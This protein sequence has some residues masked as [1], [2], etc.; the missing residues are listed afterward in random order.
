ML[1][2]FI[3]KTEVFGVVVLSDGGIGGSGEHCHS[4]TENLLGLGIGGERFLEVD[5]LSILRSLHGSLGILEKGELLRGESGLIILI[6]EG[7][8]EVGIVLH[9]E[10]LLKELDVLDGVR[11]IGVFGEHHIAGLDVSVG[12]AGTLESDGTVDDTAKSSVEVFL[13]EVPALVGIHVTSFGEELVEVGGLELGG[14]AGLVEVGA[15]LAL[16]E[17]S[18]SEELAQVLVGTGLLG[19]LFAGLEHGHCTVEEL[20]VVG[21]LLLDQ[22]VGGLIGGVA[23]GVQTPDLGAV[24]LLLGKRAV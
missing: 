3:L 17:V 10:G 19:K 8:V 7:T 12:K 14:R 21:E 5:S 6:E 11:T 24:H 23:V 1:D 15:P 22:H 18:E 20:L 9:D 2:K 13:G 4:D 16:S